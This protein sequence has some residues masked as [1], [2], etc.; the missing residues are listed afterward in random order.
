MA[1]AETPLLASG[2]QLRSAEKAR[3]MMH[4]PAAEAQGV[5][6]RMSMARATLRMTFAK[7]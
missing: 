2:G 6:C 3:K 4:Y 1:D 7:R 5:C